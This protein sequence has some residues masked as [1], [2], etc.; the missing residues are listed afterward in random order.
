MVPSDATL[1]D[2]K[3]TQKVQS[4]IDQNRLAAAE[5]D[6]FQATIQKAVDAPLVN[7][8]DTTGYKPRMTRDEA[9][10]YTRGSYFGNTEFFHGNRKGVTDSVTIEGAQPERNRRG[11]YGM[12]FYMGVDKTIGE[13]YARSAEGDIGLISAVAKVKNPY[14]SNTQE[15]TNLAKNFAGDQS[16]NV[17]SVAV[18]QFLRAKGYDSLYLKDHGYVIAFDQ[19]QVAVV[20]YEDVTDRRE[21][22]TYYDDEAVERENVAQNP[23]GAR[24]QQINNSENIDY[25]EQWEEDF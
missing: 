19:R 20:E 11:I 21:E 1:A 12:G 15:L 25:S 24:F 18:N 10:D 2:L 13:L 7:T 16:N 22:L 23:N 17:D 8:L 3:L 9:A 4:Q 5:R 14:I 6:R